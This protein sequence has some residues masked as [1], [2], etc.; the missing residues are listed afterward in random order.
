MSEFNFKLH[1][2]CVIQFQ[3]HDTTLVGPV[4]KSAEPAELTHGLTWAT[5]PSVCHMLRRKLKNTKLISNVK[6]QI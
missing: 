1:E 3:L 6:V 2:V 4:G 5:S